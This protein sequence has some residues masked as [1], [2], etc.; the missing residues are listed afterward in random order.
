M[1]TA[2]K[3]PSGKVYKTKQSPCAALKGALPCRFIFSGRSGCGK[4]NELVNL[5]TR[6][7]LFGNCFDRIYVFSPNAFAD[8]AWEPVRA[9]IKNVLKFDEK[10]EP[11]FSDTWD[12]EQI[13][14]KISEHGRIVQMQKR[15]GETMLKSAVFCID[16]WIDD[17]RICHSANNQIASLAIKGRHKKCSLILLS[18]K[19]FAISPA[20]RTNSTGILLWRCTSL[21]EY[22]SAS[23]EFSGAVS[24][25]TFKK[26]YDMAVKDEF[27]FLFLKPT[28]R[29]V[30][31]MFWLRFEKRFA[32]HDESSDDEI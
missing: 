27:S 5:L 29:S 19:I 31:D 26:I 2:I 22:I 6:N 21:K 8:H 28:A 32:I 3:A 24:K 20:V 14:E 1:P 30:Q 7:A 15:R 4:T 17:P 10:K 12:E 18:Q 25:E 9:Y 16:D 23:E 11:C 13:Q